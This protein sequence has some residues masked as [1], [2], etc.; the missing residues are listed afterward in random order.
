MIDAADAIN[1]YRTAEFAATYLI[2]KGI[3]AMLDAMLHNAGKLCGVLCIEH[4][5]SPR[6]WS[7]EEQNFATS[8]ETR[9]AHDG[10]R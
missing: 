1:D 5:G 6:L 3:G 7:K 2:P 10:R 8:C 9:S 4:V